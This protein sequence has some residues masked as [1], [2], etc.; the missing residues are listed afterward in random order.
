MIDSVLI[1][2]CWWK[3]NLKTAATASQ[4]LQDLVSCEIEVA[5]LSRRKS[6]TRNQWSFKRFGFPIVA[7]KVSLT[8]GKLRSSFDHLL[9]KICVFKARTTHC[10]ECFDM[11]RSADLLANFNYSTRIEAFAIFCIDKTRTW[12]RD[13]SSADA[14]KANARLEL[15]N[16]IQFV[17]GKC[18]VGIYTDNSWII[19]T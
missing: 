8:I 11:H 3:W 17:F 4:S 10:V 9:A 13:F 19:F 15:R 1:K 18:C 6:I 12:P 5:T 14:C 7:L 2:V 16:I